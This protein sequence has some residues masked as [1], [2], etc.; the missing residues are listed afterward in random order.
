MSIGEKAWSNLKTGD[1]YN[2]F[3]SFF[4]Y[5]YDENQQNVRYQQESGKLSFEIYQGS[6]MIVGFVD[7]QKV[8]GEAKIARTED[9]NIGMM[10]Q[11]LEENYRLEYSRYALDADNN[12]TIVFDSYLLD[13]SP[14]KLYNALKEI[15]IHSDKLDDLIIQKY[16]GLSPIN[17]GHVNELNAEEKHVKYSF[18]STRIREV[19][20][21][22]ESGS[23]RAD[24]YP[25]ALAYLF[26]DLCYSLD[27]LVRPEGETLDVFESV[28]RLWFENEKDPSVRKIEKIYAQFQKLA[29]TTESDLLQELY[30][31]RSSFGITSPTDH[32]QVKAFIESE[33]PNMDWY[34]QNN[35]HVIALSI[36]GFIVGYCLFNYAVPQ[37]VRSLFTLYYRIRQAEYFDQLGYA[38]EVYHNDKRRLNR[39]AIVSE[40]KSICDRY[41]ESYPDLDPNT[42]I[43]SFDDILAF[44]KTFLIMIAQLEVRRSY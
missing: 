13:G 14:F 21:E 37:P 44:S 1:Y 40:I 12:I 29:E 20:D 34:V 26:L 3:I 19:L 28:H 27:F 15:A 8:F 11:L 32:S 10:R 31:V 33:L 24:E 23:V 6:K 43:L 35:H 38:W 41:K 2:S 9:L 30:T 17:T 7:H 4:K 16:E 22:Y 18:L 5:L 36:P 42:R 39:K 25:G